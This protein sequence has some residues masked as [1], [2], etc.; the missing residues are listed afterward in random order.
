M[1][2][3]GNFAL[4][5]EKDS[6]VSRLSMNYSGDFIAEVGGDAD[7][8]EWQDSGTTVDFSFTWM[9]EN[10]LDLFLQANN[11][12]DEVKFLYVGIPTRSR[13]YDIYGRTFNIGASWTF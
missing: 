10:G 3:V 2:H 11:L 13:Q 4:I 5:Y 1:Q 12:T 6:I 7:E 8:D 9:F